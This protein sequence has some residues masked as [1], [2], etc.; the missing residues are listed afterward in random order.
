MSVVIFFKNNRAGYKEAINRA[1]KFGVDKVQLFAGYDYPLDMTATEIREAKKFIEDSGVT[2]ASVC[3]YMGNLM[4]YE[5]DYALLETKKRALNIAKELGTNLFTTRVGVIP[6]EKDCIQYENLYLMGKALAEYCDGIDGRIAIK[7][8]SEKASVLKGFLQ[9][10]GC[11]SLKVHIDPA[12]LVMCKTDAPSNAVVTLKDYIVL[13]NATDGLR[14]KP[15]EPQAYYAPRYYAK[16]FC[17]RDVMKNV[18][19]GMGQ[20]DFKAYFSALRGIGYSGDIILECDCACN[21]FSVME[22]L[23]FIANKW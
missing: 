4:F 21:K 13:A 22:D 19:L 15:F 8:G 3:T 12:D 16:S 11:K 7:T 10:I 2:I 6:E 9:D 20:V 18:Q 23:K 5:K 1:K 17:G 14:L